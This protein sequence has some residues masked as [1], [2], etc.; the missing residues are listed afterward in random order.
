MSE[1][2]EAGL[3]FHFL[4]DLPHILWLLRFVN[5]FAIMFA[6]SSSL[7]CIFFMVVYFDAALPCVALLFTFTV[8]RSPLGAVVTFHQFTPTVS[9]VTYHCAVCC[10]CV[11]ETAEASHM[12]WQPPHHA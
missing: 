12:M 3:S 7:C 9:F 10:D 4:I 11:R 2:Q 6:F 1:V 8:V 5:F